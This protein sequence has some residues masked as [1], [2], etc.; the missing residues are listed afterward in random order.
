IFSLTTP[1]DACRAAVI[2][3]RFKSTVDSDG[4]FLPSYH[5]EIVSRSVSPVVYATKKT[6]LL[7]PMRLPNTH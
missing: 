3:W 4:R 2:A 1:A 7:W 6:A 5:P